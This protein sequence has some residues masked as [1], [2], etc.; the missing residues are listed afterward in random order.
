MLYIMFFTTQNLRTWFVKIN[1]VCI[2]YMATTNR[3]I[4]LTTMH[5]KCGV[6]QNGYE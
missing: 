4:L 2:C 1:H 5:K 3:L 6:V